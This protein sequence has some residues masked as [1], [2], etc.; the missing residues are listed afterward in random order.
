MVIYN[1]V[2]GICATR[3]ECK[4]S[5]KQALIDANVIEYIRVKALYRFNLNKNDDGLWEMRPSSS[6]FIYDV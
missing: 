3:E 4:E 1:N 2:K 6:A 5:Y